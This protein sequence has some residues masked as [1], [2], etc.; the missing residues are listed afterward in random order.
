V[1]ASHPAADPLYYWSYLGLDEVLGSQRLVSASG[2][3]EPAHDE[4][5]FIV[6]HQ[7]FE[8]WFKQILWEL[9]AAIETL[10]REPVPEPA[11]GQV[12]RNLERIVAIQPLLV[13][14]FQVLAT[15]T[16]LD[17][18]DFRDELIPA[19][20]F[21]SVQFRLIEN[22]LGLPPRAR[23]KIKGAR[24]TTR[25]SEE[26]AQR[27]DASESEPTLLGVLDRWLSRTP[28]LR[29]GGFDFWAA[30]REAVERMLERD[31][32]LIEHNP[33]VDEVVR[34]QQ[35]DAF[36]L[37]RETFAPLFDR[38][39]WEGLRA[40]GKRRLSQESFLAALLISLYRD[41]PALHLPFR[42]LTA[43]IDLDEGFTAFRNAHAQLVHRTI[44]GRI[45]TGGTSGHEYLQAAARRHQ[46]FTDLFDL[47]TYHL[48][49]KELPRL[50]EQV[51]EQMSFRYAT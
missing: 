46:V 23:L 26:H 34:D 11:M 40:Q 51:R 27:L 22:R 1:S 29:F 50:P 33:S 5:L 28:F 13:Q 48:P 17:F 30:Y 25:L 19:S 8:L 49:R 36:E 32:R 7:A 35:L 47:A 38:D 41:E 10:G 45:G 39:A 31:R 2:G 44:G 18:L 16:P 3:R 43:L 6:T 4:M 24:Y 20:G 12:V 9:D 14:Q 15:M 42:L 37:T 21:Q